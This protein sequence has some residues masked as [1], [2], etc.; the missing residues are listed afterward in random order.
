MSFK[1]ISKTVLLWAY[2]ISVVSILSWL[3]VPLS[4]RFTNLEPAPKLSVV[5]VQ[6][7][8]FDGLHYLDIAKYGY[9][10]AYTDKS[11]SFFPLYPYLLRIVSGFHPSAA[12]GVALSLALFIFALHF[13]YKLISL[14]SNRV[15]ARNSLLLLLIFPTALFFGSVYTESLFLLISVLVFYFARKQH[16]LL[17]SVFGLLASATKITGIFLYPAILYEWY[18]SKKRSLESFIYSVLLPPIGLL[19]YS[20]YQW[21]KTGDPLYFV[22]LQSNFSGRSISKI[23]LLPQVL[24][25]YLK[26]LASINRPDPIFFTSVLELGCALLVILL[27][28]VGIKR[29][30]LSYY[31]YLLPAFILPTLTGTF[32]SMPRFI[33]VMFPLF[34]VLSGIFTHAPKSLKILYLVI[35]VI[36]GII[37]ISFFVRGHF[38]A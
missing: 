38:I 8:N 22:H 19:S 3:V 21:I 30:R 24:W 37:S 33:L 4:S 20:Y 17:A 29:L 23:I 13:L 34:T 2:L 14:D 18:I 12:F 26:I 15:E 31:I 27:L 35:S 6:W 5:W 36:L 9:G 28:V 1:T 32:L 16:F 25:R 10:S 11:Y 7:S